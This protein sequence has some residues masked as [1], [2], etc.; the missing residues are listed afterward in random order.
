MFACFPNLVD[1]SENQ[2]Q[3]CYLGSRDIPVL[4][5]SCSSNTC[6]LDSARARS[7]DIVQSARKSRNSPSASQGISASV[8]KTSAVAGLERGPIPPVLPIGSDKYS[9]VSDLL[10][11][12]VKRAQPVFEVTLSIL[13]PPETLD[14][15]STNVTGSEDEL[16]NFVTASPPALLTT[17][18]GRGFNSAS[19]SLSRSM[20]VRKLACG[21][22]IGG[23]PK[24]AKVPAYTSKVASSRYCRTRSCEKVPI[25]NG[26]SGGAKR[27][28]A[29]RSLEDMLNGSLAASR[30]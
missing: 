5:Y 2:P 30:R 26:R 7:Y 14:S 15:D 18:S 9:I 8:T 24:K 10:H 3:E 19:I 29:E 23:L 28:C 22:S 6:A 17:T 27:F 1:V 13:T 12:P 11:Q 20:H 25:E 16:E 4:P 21:S